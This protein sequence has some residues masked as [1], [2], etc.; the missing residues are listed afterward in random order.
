VFATNRN[1]EL[2][3]LVY[4]VSARTLPTLVSSA[5]MQGVLG[6]PAAADLNLLAKRDDVFEGRNGL[7][8]TG[9][10][11]AVLTCFLIFVSALLPC[12]RALLFR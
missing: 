2:S 5:I 7:I 8:L 9:T 3:S 1:I 12:M 10:L 6:A 11:T 4:F